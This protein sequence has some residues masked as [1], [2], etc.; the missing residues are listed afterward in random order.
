[1]KSEKIHLQRKLTKLKVFLGKLVKPYKLSKRWSNK[2]GRKHKLPILEMK[3]D[4]Y[5]IWVLKTL[6]G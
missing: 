5:I 3:E 1:M 4:M 6:K 2:K